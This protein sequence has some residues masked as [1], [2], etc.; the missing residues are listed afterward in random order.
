MTGRRNVR[1]A[2]RRVSVGA[3][4]VVVAL[5]LSACAATYQAD[6][7]PRGPERVEVKPE[8]PSFGCSS[9]KC[10]APPELEK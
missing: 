2:G 7:G 8:W 4:L 10:N 1:S 3:L 6:N 5:T 9:G